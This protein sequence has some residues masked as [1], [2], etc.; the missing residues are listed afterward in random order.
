M[1][2]E[3][4]NTGTGPSNRSQACVSLREK[5]PVFE[6]T[7]YEIERVD[8]GLLMRFHYSFGTDIQF[9]PETFIEFVDDRDMETLGSEALERIVFQLGLVEMLSYWKAACSPLIRVK[10][11]VLNSEQIAWWMDLLCRGMG[12]FFYVNQIQFDEKKF[13]RIVSEAGN[14]GLTET[15]TVIKKNVSRDM[16][17]TSGGKDSV[18]TMEY[19][20]SSG[21]EFDCL[22]LNPTKAAL[23]VAQQAGCVAPIIVRRKIDPRLLELNGAGYLNGHTPFSA[24]LAILGTL[25]AAIKGSR[26][27][28]VSNERS[29][30]EAAA[31][32][33][34][35]EVNHQYSKSFRFEQEFRS[36]SKRYLANDVEYFSLMRPLYELQI[37][38]LFSKHR[39]YFSIFRSC[40]RASAKNGWCGRCPKCLFV[41]TAL[42]PFVS[43][44]EILAI[45]GQDLFEWA[46]AYELLISL[47]GLD[48]D[49]PFE[50]VGTREE[51]MAALFL[52]TEKY[53]EGNLA[54]PQALLDVDKNVLSSRN[55]LPNVVRSVLDAWTDD[56]CIPPDLADKLRKQLAI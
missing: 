42:Y 40:N 56:H 18:V 34:G 19:L 50:C 6:Y 44:K 21:R 33:L 54:L 48:R 9:A 32:F 39:Q 1:S 11:G 2:T 23:D 28:I 49:K 51:T 31:E 35:R 43:R 5:H 7:R 24:M 47:L 12:E 26:N 41:F 45:F 14:S 29:A 4:I 16:V 15:H 36:Y 8:K 38:R 22:L 53:K 30:E 20:R 10:A 55:D 3:P 46:G 52:C 27:L 25:V 13:V 37:A 17:L